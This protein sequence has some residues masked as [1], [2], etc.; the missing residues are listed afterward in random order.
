MHRHKAQEFPILGTLRPAG[1]RPPPL[2]NRGEVLWL[3]HAAADE[4]QQQRR[5]DAD[6]E[7][8]APTIGADDL[9]DLSGDQRADRA[10]GHHDAE[11]A[12]PVRL[13]KG[14]SHERNADDDLGAGADSGQEAENA[15]L[16]RSLREALQCCED[17]EDQDTQ[18][19]HKCQKESRNPLPVTQTGLE[20]ASAPISTNA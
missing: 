18:R 11:D 5:R 17:A 16:R 4:H 8:P 13:G 3:D 9:V 20:R 10:A 12:G 19:Q 6:K 14:F 2:A 7:H 15:E 1:Q